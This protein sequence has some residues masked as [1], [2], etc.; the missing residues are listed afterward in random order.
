LRRLKDQKKCKKAKNAQKTEVFQ[1]FLDKNAHI[2]VDRKKDSRKKDSKLSLPPAAS[3]RGK[4]GAK[5]EQ[6]I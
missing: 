6:Q 2:E 1:A 5:P 3:S 4:M